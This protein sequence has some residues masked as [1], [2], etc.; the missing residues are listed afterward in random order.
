MKIPPKLI[1]LDLVGAL[2]VAVGVLNMMGEGGIEGVV[3]FVVGLLLMVP[4]IT[5]ILKSI[6]SGRNQDR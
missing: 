2:L 6:P 4:L 1:V 3:Y 5:H